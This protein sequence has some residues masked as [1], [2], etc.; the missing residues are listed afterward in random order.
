MSACS[1][2]RSRSRVRLRLS[3]ARLAAFAALT[4][5]VQPTQ[6]TAT[7]PSPDG[8]LQ[9]QLNDLVRRPEGRPACSDRRGFIT[10]G[11]AWPATRHL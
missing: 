9:Q 4:A 11:I 6:A 3:V 10:P 7:P 5:L 2:I 1:G 8:A